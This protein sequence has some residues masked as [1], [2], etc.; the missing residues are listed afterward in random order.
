MLT[1]C[2]NTRTQSCETCLLSESR[3]ID[4]RI[5][6]IAEQYALGDEPW[7]LGFSGGKD[8]SAVLKLVYEA[9]RR[10]SNAK[11]LV[12]VVYCDT[13]VEIPV[14]RE[15]V[16][17]TFRRLRLE[18]KADGIPL[19]ITIAQPNIQDRYFVKVIGRGYPPPTNK[20][21]WCTDRLR[22][23]PI[24]R[25]LKAQHA[26]SAT[27][28][29][30]T[31][32][33]ESAERD[34]VLARYRNENAQFYFRQHG[35]PNIRLFAPIVDFGTRD[36]WSILLSVTKPTAVDGNQV[37]SI[38]KDAGAECPVVRDTHGTPCGNGRF[39]CWTCTVVRQDKAVTNLVAQGY[40]EM[41]PLL[42][43]R[44]WLAAFRDQPSARCRVRRNGV[45]G[46]GPL[47][48]RARRETL[49]RL[50]YAE[51][52]SGQQLISKAEITMIRLLWKRDR[53]SASY[54]E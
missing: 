37:L 40:S 31:R 49:E 13:G 23:N 4:A 34:R 45:M 1:R 17:R 28:I 22:I 54:R 36:V 15:H 30:G 9:V 16:R 19:R 2:A 18:A 27:V 14:V 26:K 35:A 12:N 20:F 21:R 29:V 42:E 5:G 7:L 8:S 44:N 38:Y 51:R 52:R 10:T 41:E 32:G 3:W 53:N 6:L 48:L 11:R 50:R 33:G 43:F 25:V 39:G 24:R 46:S 47:T